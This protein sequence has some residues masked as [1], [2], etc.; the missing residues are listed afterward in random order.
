MKKYILIFLAVFAFTA[1]GPAYKSVEDESFEEG[2][3]KIQTSMFVLIETT[4][5][6]RI[7]YCRE[8]KVMYSVQRGPKSYGL[9]TPLYNRDG[10]L[11]TY[12]H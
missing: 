4:D 11:M 8:T 2:N 9:M 7:V 3:G 10:S 5:Y 6:W 12:K 1:C